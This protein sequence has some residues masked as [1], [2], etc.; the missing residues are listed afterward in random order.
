MLVELT[1]LT[2]EAAGISGDHVQTVTSVSQTHGPAIALLMQDGTVMM[3]QASATQTV[4]SVMAVINASFLTTLVA[5]PRE[6]PMVPVRAQLY[7]RDDG[8]G[9]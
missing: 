9:P 1:L 5:N 7:T 8:L 4:A 3:L 2:G 6:A